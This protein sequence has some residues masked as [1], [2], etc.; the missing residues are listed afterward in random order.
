MKDFDDFL[1][2][3]VIKKQSVDVPRAKDLVSEANRKFNQIKRIFDKIGLDDENAND[4]IESSCDVI[5]G[6]IRAK[7]FLKGFS[8]SGKGS[9]EAEVSYLNKLNFKDDEIEFI[10][11]L[12]YFRNG[13]LYYGKR[14]NKEYS[15]KVINFL[16]KIVPR[17][18]S[19]Q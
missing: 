2:L 3:G 10:N 18:K 9:H 8:A 14:F 12:R 5:L 7:M 13:I 15:E 19:L 16:N 1:K 11:K 17:L 4:I 6:L